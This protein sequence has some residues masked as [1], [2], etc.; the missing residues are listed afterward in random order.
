MI[1]G[2][3]AGV[4]VAFNHYWRV[5]TQCDAPEPV[6]IVVRTMVSIRAIAHRPSSM[7]TH[8]PNELLFH[9]FSFL[10]WIVCKDDDISSL[11]SATPDRIG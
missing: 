8:I 7:L 2:I 11:L 3:V 5:D 9:I 1:G 6:Q 10:P 4:M